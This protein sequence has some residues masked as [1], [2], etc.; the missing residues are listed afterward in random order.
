MTRESRNIDL[1]GP[2]LTEIPNQTCGMVFNVGKCKVMHTGSKN[3]GFNYIMNNQTLESTA[4][5]R[6]IFFLL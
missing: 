6:D 5:E 1:C 4:E 2:R 3:P